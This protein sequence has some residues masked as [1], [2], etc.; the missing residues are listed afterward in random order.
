M[1]EKEYVGFLGL[2]RQEENQII[3]E[4][5]Q[6]AQG[7]QGHAWG[8]VIPLLLRRLDEYREYDE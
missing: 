5:R 4:A 6:E 8:V 1:S 3:E 7:R 2:T